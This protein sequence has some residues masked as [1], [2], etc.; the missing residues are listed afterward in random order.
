[1]GA[2]FVENCSCVFTATLFSL[3]NPQYA[4]LREGTCLCHTC[5]P[6]QGNFPET[7]LCFCSAILSVST[8]CPFM[9]AFKR[10]LRGSLNTPHSCPGV[11]LPKKSPTTPFRENSSNVTQHR[12][13]PGGYH[14]VRIGD[15]FE[16]RYVVL[17]KLGFG[18]YS[19]VW[20]AKDIKYADTHPGVN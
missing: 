18:Q 10:I 3:T 11:S 14:P 19:T 8:P 15:T 2:C 17:R 12:Y 20:L 16:D 13:A 6:R 1:V 9:K 4:P 7:G 5:F